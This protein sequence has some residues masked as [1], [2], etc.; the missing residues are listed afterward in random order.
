MIRQR[1]EFNEH[2]ETL[3]EAIGAVAYRQFVAFLVLWL[4][5]GM[6]MTCQQHGMMTLLDMDLHS[7]GSHS[8]H[9]AHE[10]SSGEPVC[11]MREHQPGAAMQFSMADIGTIPAK[12]GLSDV[13]S[14]FR[15]PGLYDCLIP[16]WEEPPPTPPP[17][18]V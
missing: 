17:R 16:Q 14:E 5:I 12:I 2:T 15:L 11:S 18:F 9:T 13:V 1:N 10:K 4:I 6:P 3:L 7:A 8:D